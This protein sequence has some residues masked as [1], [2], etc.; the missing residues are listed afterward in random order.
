MV[1]LLDKSESRRLGSQSGA[2][3]VKQHKWFVKMNWGLLRNMTPPVR[4][5]CPL[6]RMENE[7]VADATKKNANLPAI[8]LDSL[9]LSCRVVCSVTVSS[10]I[11]TRASPCGMLPFKLQRATTDCAGDV[12]RG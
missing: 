6:A 9:L 8:G 11:K 12:E 3:Q 2:S 10:G 1:R 7:L 5:F 4:V